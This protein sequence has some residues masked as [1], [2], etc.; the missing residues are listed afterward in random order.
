MT[1]LVQTPPGYEPERRYILDVVLADWLGIEWRLEQHVRSDVR[2]SADGDDHSPAVILPD[3][4]FSTAERDWLAP[5]SLPVLPLPRV[6]SDDRGPNAGRRLPVLYGTAAPSAIEMD[7]SCT[8]LSVDVFGAAFA[9]LTRYEEAVI[10]GRDRHGRFAAESSIAGKEGFLSVPLV[11]TYVELLWTALAATWTRL[12]R[13]DRSYQ[14]AISHDVD[15]PLSTLARTP[16]DIVRQFGADILRRRDLGLAFRRARTVVVGDRA[17]GYRS[18][19]HN[20]F[21]F[22]MDVSDRNGLTSAFYFQSHREQNRDGGA[23][24][25]LEHS[26][27]RSL[28]RRV[29]ARGHEI[30]Y[31]AGFGTYLDPGR[32]AAEFEHLRDVATDSGISQERWGGRQHYLQWAPSTTWR[33]WAGAGLDY[34]CTVAFADAVGFRTGTCHE[35][36]VF[37][38][39]ERR[40][41]PLREQPFQ[42]MDVTLFGYMGLDQ[43]AAAE[44]VAAIGAECRRYRGTLGVLWHNDS[45]L[46]TSREKAWYASMMGSVRPS[47]G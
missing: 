12:Q 37:D 4:L 41:L 20:T 11:D 46:R 27:I 18:D 9:M 35:F 42:I 31:H 39:A 30:G 10:P 13:R 5:D 43:H 33:N 32:T 19:P 6:T 1:L 3:V 44:A 21:D 25:A 28:I 29:H 16:A 14:V 47:A 26:W 2:I 7:G 24:Y 23:L 36:G 34:D 17:A 8:R 22:L 15:D 40:P 45:V 38:L